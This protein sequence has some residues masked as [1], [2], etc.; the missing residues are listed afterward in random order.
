M[1]WESRLLVAHAD[2]VLGLV[3]EGLRVARGAAGHGVAGLLTA[4]L[5]VLCGG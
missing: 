5:G 4:R 3:E 2:G 1:M